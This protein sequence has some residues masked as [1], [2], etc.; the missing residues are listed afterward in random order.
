MEYRVLGPIEVASDGQVASL[1][2]PKQRALLAI[3]LLHANEI[4]PVDR[5]VDLLW[6]DRPPRSAAHAVQVYV[7]ELRSALEPLGCRDAIRWQAPGYVLRLGQDELDAIT[8]ERL[9]AQGERELQADNVADAASTLG[10]ARE[11]WRGPP[12]A[13]FVYDEFAQEDIRRLT[14]TWLRGT[15][16]LADVQLRR[17]S[18]LDGL[19]LAEAAI[20][21]DPLRERPRELQL[22]ALYRLGR[23]ADALRAFESYRR[24]LDDELDLSPAA[25][26]VHLRDSILVHDP[27]LGPVVAAPTP[28]AARGPS[29]NPYKGLRSF[30]EEDA[31]DFFGRDALVG[32]IV[33]TLDEG[34][35]LVT[36]VGPS[37]SGKSSILGAGLVPAL[38]AGALPGSSDWAIVRMRPGSRPVQ[39]L[40]EA[41]TSVPPG[42]EVLLVV[43]Q[44][45]D[46]FDQAE[47][48]ERD[49]F[50]AA[51]I[52]AH[53][54][55]DPA[56]AVLALR[57]D[58]YD[59][60]LLHGGFAAA[61]VPGVVSVIP[62]TAEEL[63]SAIA[64]PAERVGATVE[65]AL[66]AELVSETI[67]QPGALPLLEHV[68]TELFERCTD[69]RLTLQAC[70]DLGGLPA[71]LG[72][73]A[74]AV[75]DDLDEPRQQVVRRVFLRLV[76]LGDRATPGARRV[77]VRDLTELGADAVQVSEVVRAFESA[78]LLT[79]D[80]DPLS[81][82]PTVE[83][84]HEALLTAWPRL[85][86]WIDEHRAD[87]REHEALAARAA[88]WRASGRQ[89]EDLLAG[90]RLD[91][92]TRWAAAS[93]YPLTDSERGFL[94]ASL[95]RRRRA[96]DAE[97]ARL[98][99]E[100]GLARRA[101]R[102]L[103]GL[104]AVAILLVGAVGYAV[105]AAPGAAPDV[106]FVYP[107][108]GEGMYDS[109]AA[110]VQRAVEAND[111]DAQT[112]V[113]PPDT[114]EERL[115]RLADQGADL[116]VVGHAWSNPA[117]E[118]VARD[119]PETRFLATDYWGELPNVSVP[120]LAFEQGAFLSGAAAAL[121]SRT[122]TVGVVFDADTDLEW[123]WAGGFL[124]GVS[125]IDATV[126]VQRTYLDPRSSGG[127]L[128]FGAVNRAARELYRSGADV[129]FYAGTAAP[130]GLFEAASSESD[131]LGR[132]LW[133]IARDTD[134]Y[135]VLPLV[136]RRD[137][138]DADTWRGHVLT[139]LV[140]RYDMALESM[141]DAYA[142]GLL[143]PGE[144][145]FG[146]PDGSFELARSGGSLDAVWSRIEALR[147]RVVSGEIEVPAL[148]P[149]RGPP[150]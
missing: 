84:A 119:H 45:E 56:R 117:V 109:I 137:G 8:V 98:A 40:D 6:P 3:L 63:E 71:A 102:R 134:W 101:R 23:S 30:G 26:L 14:E 113:E 148:P 87:L 54:G 125:A 21:E 34:L 13:D 52:G 51:L 110:G 142:T 150:H 144:R 57:A 36:L 139:S 118:R 128:A 96:A 91:E 131:A 141:L 100:R 130:L 107:G 19:A 104:I 11:L 70:R 76:R 143:P 88:E 111:L 18:L 127:P 20:R 97:A 62:M 35:R 66:L 55:R 106:A 44:A 85:A 140:T 68:L 77:P 103:V 73:R 146:A 16:L 120:R 90:N 1:G 38:R 29:R 60:P 89:P 136:G 50:L 28:I 108:P 86:G 115:V 112:V 10:R 95:E 123:P 27:S 61:F 2:P 147:E 132:H 145:R 133:A 58:R 47:P 4:V 5:C 48:D 121:A 31:A 72:R 65:P 53:G 138:H 41:T 78:R 39:A 129:V 75:Y 74:E 69:G 135:V 124:A 67:D 126:E 49:A 37:G 43:D 99:R 82:G 105:T 92:A 33:A 22:L 42:T 17:G 24:A 80:R 32:R 114:L 79:I 149:D 64:G 94:E 15:E 122:G 81:G 59:Q 93:A 12:L 7:S 46:V 83:V 9:V 116:I 25:A